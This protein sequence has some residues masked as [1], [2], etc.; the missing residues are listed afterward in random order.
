M[1]YGI[2][3][4]AWL[5]LLAC[6]AILAWGLTG[7]CGGGGNGPAPP[8]GSLSGTVVDLDTQA[9]L[10]QADVS[11]S[12]R[13]DTT[14]ADGS[15][16]LD[17]LADGDHTLTVSRVGYQTRQLQVTVSGDTVLPAPISLAQ[18]GGGPPGP[19][20]TISG[21]VTLNGTLGVGDQIT[22]TAVDQS[23]ASNNDSDT[24]SAPGPY[25]LLVPGAA[26]YDVTASAPGFQSQVQ[27][28]NLPNLGDTAQNVDFTLSP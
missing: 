26:T 23:D 11:A 10:A 17:N 5:P 28:V 6:A 27:V 8:Q 24:L 18:T 14:P 4:S 12:G 2:R 19:P 22:V 20:A 21:T 13:S 9:P 15:F 25:G 1:A 7:G 16:L 3:D